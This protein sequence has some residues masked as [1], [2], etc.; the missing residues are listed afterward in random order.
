MRTL[1]L[2]IFAIMVSLLMSVP[3]SAQTDSRNR[4]KETIIQDGLAQLPSKNLK[5][6]NQVMSE[7]AGTGK[8]GM[9]MLAGMLV[10]AKEGKNATFEYAIDGIVSYVSLPKN[11]KLKKGVLQGL[12]EGLKKCKDD[13]NRAFLLTE[14]QKIAS[15]EDAP[16]LASLLKDKYLK[17]YA[18]TA[19]ASVKGTDNEV[20]KLIKESTEPDASLAYLAYCKKLQNVEDKLLTWADCNDDKV[21]AAVYNALTVCGGAKSVK[22]LGKAAKALNYANEPLGTTDA[23]LQLLN[24]CQDNKLVLSSAKAL[25]KSDKPAVRCSGLRLV[26]LKDKANAAKNIAAA[27]KDPCRQ[28]RNTA[29]DFAEQTAG[30]GIYAQIAAKKYANEAMTDVVRWLGNHHRTNQ[31]PEVL[32]AISQQNDADWAK[33]GI[34][35]AGRI[36]GEKALQALVSELGGQYASEAKSALLAFNGEINAEIVKALDSENTNIQ[37]YALQLASERH[38]Y[39]AYKKV[40]ELTKA[41]NAEVK[42]EAYKALQGVSS[43]A[44]FDELCS[45]MEKGDNVSSLQT[46]AKKSILALSSSKQYELVAKR[47]EKTSQPSLYYPLLAQA[48]NSQSIAKLKEEYEKGQN[49]EA[50]YKALLQVDNAE[51]IDVLYDMAKANDAKKD[52]ILIRYL[53]LVHK[54]D[55]NGVVKYQLYRKA[56][57]LNPSKADVKNNSLKYLAGCKILPSMMLAATYMNNKDTEKRA[58]STV[59]DI[60]SKTDDMQ[61][62][63]MVKGVLEKAMSIFKAQTNNADAG[64]AVDEIKGQLLPKMTN[65]GYAQA[66]VADTGKKIVLGDKNY[67]NFEFYMD[68]KVSND[69]V[70]LLRSM[71]QINLSASKVSVVGGKKEVSVNKDEWNT[72]HVKVVND[73]ILVENNG[74]T[75]VENHVMQNTPATKAILYEGAIEMLKQKANI[76]IRG[77]YLKELPST[78]VFKLSKEEEKEGFEVL[79]DG[80]SLDKWQG[81][82]IDYVPVDGNIFVNARYGGNGNLYTKKKYSDVIYRFEFCFAEPGVNNGVGLRTNIGTDAAYDGM[83]IQ[84]LDHDAPIYK[85]LHPYQQHGAVYGIIVPKRVKFGKVGTW[86]TEEIRAVGDHITV[87]VNGEVVLDGNIREAC[88]GHNV[89]PNGEKTN[90]YTVDH[91]NHPGLFNKE[92]YISFC[93][94]GPGVKFR[95]VRIKD[96]SKKQNKK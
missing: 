21:K 83:E 91:K 75:V 84:V 2:Y 25:L 68:W 79:F 73:R 39:V 1:K 77:F 71:P 94:H 63:E 15:A 8:E 14:I 40:V 18:V 52:D 7:M 87:T 64:Y 20:E 89:A 29:L 27:L 86:N 85:G 66:K 23:Y 88:Q 59:K 45:M 30:E 54:S 62:G 4:T 78:P 13:A 34:E 96:L 24:N 9:E 43:L 5:N 38:I 95:N 65:P 46:A 56:L 69:I 22:K 26:L 6:L 19:L 35:A 32:A 53:S 47:L 67:E 92:G 60:V 93:G 58:A 41:N 28:Y 57:E 61:G 72:L 80:R 42:K 3:V 37:I 49:K 76:E 70:M 82:M 11:A 50:A 10:P 74:E 17:D 90:P 36:G 31:L 12:C 44:N 51:M 81:N 55:K 48:G 16:F 33:A